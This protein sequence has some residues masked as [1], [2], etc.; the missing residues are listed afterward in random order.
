M[1]RLLLLSGGM[2]SI[3]LAWSLHPECALT[4]DYGQLPANAELRSAKA[5]CAALNLQHHIVRID[6]RSIGSGDLAGIAPLSVAPMSEWWPFRNQLLITIGASVAL[7]HE[8]DTITI[9]AVATDS[10][11]ADGRLDF[12]N[13]MSHLLKVQEGRLSIE[14]PALQETTSALCK[15]VGV[16]L[17]VLALAHSCYVSNGACGMCGGCNKHRESMLELGY[18]NY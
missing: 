13:A 17:E 12:F 18:G 4:I 8:M 3:A 1:K 10:L 14:V 5:V 2:D 16:P 11:H 7:N 9:G 15:R 6:C